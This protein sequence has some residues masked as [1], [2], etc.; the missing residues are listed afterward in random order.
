MIKIIRNFI[1]NNKRKIEKPLDYAKRIGVNVGN[2]VLLATKHFPTEPYLV[3]IG[4]NCRIAKDVKF[5]THGG[6]WTLRYVFKDENLDFFGKVKIG[7]NT[8]IGESSMI[9][10]G[11]TIGDNCMVAAGSVVVKSVPDNTV[12]G[13]NPAKYIGDVKDTYNRMKKY[14]LGIKK[15]NLLE[16]RDYLL[17]LDDDKFMKKPFIKI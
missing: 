15:M 11:V 16:K 4:D 12:V 10:P 13:G 6:A 2:N 14:D 17:S 1:K 9:M 3:T 5:F 8:Y 7:N